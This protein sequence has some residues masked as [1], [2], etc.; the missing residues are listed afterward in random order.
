MI[1]PNRY[2]N[3]SFY[4]PATN[5]WLT[6]LRSLSY[7]NSLVV[8]ILSSFPDP[9]G[10]YPIF[11]VNDL[12]IDF[13]RPSQDVA[14][15]WGRDGTYSSGTIAIYNESFQLVT[16]LPVSLPGS[17]VS[18]SL[19]PYHQR[20]KRVILRR[21]NVPDNRYGHIYLDNFQ[22]TPITTQSP[23]GN[24]ESVSIEQGAP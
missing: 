5:T 21:S 12:V 23:V 18:F 11:S 14:F 19:N 4:A 10:Y 24:L 8:G 6:H 1:S 15:W 3:V 2:A 22:F 13:A 7:P 16:S 9:G 20:I 17:W